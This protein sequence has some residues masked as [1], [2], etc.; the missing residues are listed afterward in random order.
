[1]SSLQ[2]IGAGFG[3]TGTESFKQALE[4][5]YGA[6]C[7]HMF[8]VVKHRHSG[9]WIDVAEG[10]EPQWDT[11]FKGFAAAV[12]FPASAYWRE[13]FAMNPNAKVMLL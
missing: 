8:E 9:Y 6:P 3:R 4:I 1:M 13:I 2:V 5:L 7:Y 12:D 11:I 10:K